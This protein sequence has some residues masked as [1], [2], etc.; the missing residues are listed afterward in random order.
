MEVFDPAAP[1]GR[2]ALLSRVAGSEAEGV[3]MLAEACLAVPRSGEVPFPPAIPAAPPA[4][5]RESAPRRVAAAGVASSIL[6]FISAS[7]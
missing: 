6:F 2:P 7:S 4:A 5:P 3:R 1:P